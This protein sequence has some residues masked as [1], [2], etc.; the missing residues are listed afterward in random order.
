MICTFYYEERKDVIYYIS[1][2]RGKYYKTKLFINNNDLFH[3]RTWKFNTDKNEWVE[4]SLKE[5]TLIT[6][7]IM[8]GVRWK[9]ER[10]EYQNR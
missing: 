3:Y 2:F 6:N 1:R 8:D 7:K 4:V 5:E 9:D 10:L